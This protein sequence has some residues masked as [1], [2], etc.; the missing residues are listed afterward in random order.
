MKIMSRGLF[1][2]GSLVGYYTIKSFL[3]YK[4]LRGIIGLVPTCM[5]LISYVNSRHLRLQI[6]ESIYLSAD[7]KNVFIQ[8]SAGFEEKISIRNIAVP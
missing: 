8:D 3:N 5:L 4:F 1:I 2:G 7:G 6:I